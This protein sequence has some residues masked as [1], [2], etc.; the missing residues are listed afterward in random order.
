MLTAFF[1]T[2]LGAVKTTLILTFVGG[3]IGGLSAI[4]GRFSIFYAIGLGALITVGCFGSGYMQALVNAHHQAEIAQLESE[5]AALKHDLDAVNEVRTFEQSKLEEQQ[6][7]LDEQQ[8]AMDE[9]NATI[10]KHAGDNKCTGAFKDE[11]DSIRKLK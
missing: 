6:K 11:L 2:I 1:G 7:R 3:L 8:K 9:I 4:L 5:K 10:D